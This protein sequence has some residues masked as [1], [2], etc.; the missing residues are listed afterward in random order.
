M[1]A[2]KKFEN[3]I[4]AATRI[5]SLLLLMVV[6]APASSDF[7]DNTQFKAKDPQ[8]GWGKSYLVN[9][10][11]ICEANCAKDPKCKHWTWI[12]KG[13]LPGV[14]RDGLQ[15]ICFPIVGEIKQPKQNSCCISGSSGI[16]NASNKT[17][18]GS[19][20]QQTGSSSL[21]NDTNFMGSDI[22]FH[23]SIK[24]PKQCADL[25]VKNAACKSWTWVKAGKGPMGSGEFC[26]IKGE[27]PSPT[28]DACCVSGHRPGKGG[29]SNA[30]MSAPA[31][32]PTSSSA[33]IS[34][35]SVLQNIN[36]LGGD[37]GT[38]QNADNSAACDAACRNNP[39]CKFWTWVKP[40]MLPDIQRP[41]L[42]GYCALKNDIPIL[43][44]DKCCD[45]GSTEPG[46]LAD[47]AAAGKSFNKL[48]GTNLPGGDMKGLGNVDNPQICQEACSKISRCVSWTWVKPGAIPQI[49]RPDM[50]G[51]CALKD[52]VPNKLADDCCVS[53]IASIVQSVP[54]SQAG[55]TGQS[56]VVPDPPKGKGSVRHQDQDGSIT[57][58]AMKRGAPLGDGRSEDHALSQVEKQPVRDGM[59]CSE[60]KRKLDLATAELQILNPN[61]DK[62]WP[63]ALYSSESVLNGSYIPIKQRRAPLRITTSAMN[64]PI[65]YKDVP[66]PSSATVNNAIAALVKSSRGH[67][68]PEQY[69]VRL[70]K[71]YSK[72]D[73]SVKVTGS[74]K[75]PFTKAS[76][77]FNF[78]EQSVKSRVLIDLQRVYYR[79][80]SILPDMNGSFFR[81]KFRIPED[82]VYVSSVSY[83][84]R[85]LVGLESSSEM[86]E[87]YA[88]AN[89]SFS[90]P[91]SNGSVSAE[92]KYK[93]V[94]SNVKL[95]IAGFGVHGVEIKKAAEGGIKGIDKFIANL[96][97]EL[98]VTPSAP[99]YPLAYTFQFANN[100]EM[101]HVQTSGEYVNRKCGKYAEKIQVEVRSIYCE[102]HDDD[103]DKAEIYGKIWI[104][105]VDRNGVKLAPE[106][107]LS[108]V[109][110]ERS[111]DKPYHIAENHEIPINSTRS[112]VFN[113]DA[114][115]SGDAYLMVTGLLREHDGS[116]A[117]DKFGLR[118][119]P[120]IVIRDLLSGREDPADI[121]EADRRVDKEVKQIHKDYHQTRFTEDGWDQQMIVLFKVKA[122]GE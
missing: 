92:A 111:S 122:A 104:D 11:R 79:I 49:P 106:G 24:D 72:K 55:D 40:G 89:A 51:F 78:N 53:G 105:A 86:D 21:L 45:S 80:G 87:L 116:S 74:Y 27:I 7:R 13:A 97:E 109:V 37:I 108:N 29:A 35:N 59:V 50:A 42:A 63:G 113:H 8:T 68:A 94:L 20:P 103:G 120:K 65:T 19:A 100:H 115:R 82:W 73:F 77:V 62:L 60:E 4:S 70:E 75:S 23:F 66:R 64:V 54:G 46:Y 52:K 96:G 12:K 41:K 93:D 16:D 57:V 112:F 36:I 3:I 117:N 22:G 71:I 48:Q 81:D 98:S 6:A 44:N 101:S 34:S 25:C 118:F 39:A 76:G 85:I 84:K 30:G 56:A 83:G 10:S 121:R 43:A 33:S 2:A 1:D 91:A 31:P 95:R 28:K 15:A 58:S 99:G 26:A 119:Q 14:K 61:P 17:Q 114:I 67:E 90:S 18:E 47:G 5:F 38:V 107:G 69:H 110:W 102:S 32:M 88:A 9:D